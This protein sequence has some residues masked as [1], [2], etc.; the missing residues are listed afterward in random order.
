MQLFD[1]ESHADEVP[2]AFYCIEAPQKEA[3]EPHD[4]FDDAKNRFGSDFPLGINF[5]ASWRLQPMLHPGHG[6]GIVR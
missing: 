2:F 3:S 5:L 1:V 6:I 4:R